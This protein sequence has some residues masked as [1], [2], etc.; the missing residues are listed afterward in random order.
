MKRGTALV[1]AAFWVGLHGIAFSADSMTI[2]MKNAKGESVGEAK[3]TQTP[4]GVL[5]QATL[6]KLPREST[7]FTFT[8][9]V[10]VSLRLSRLA[11]ISIRT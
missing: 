6:S 11:I 8:P 9:L 10:N 1:A 7:G 3:L 4:S 2:P 5:I